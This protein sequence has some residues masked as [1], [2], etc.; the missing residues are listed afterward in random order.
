MCSWELSWHLTILRQ[1]REV[2]VDLPEYEQ[3]FRAYAKAY[4]RSLGESVDVGA[5]RGFFAEAFISASIGGPLRLERMTRLSRRLLRK[6]WGQITINF[7]D[8]GLLACLQR[9]RPPVCYTCS[10]RRK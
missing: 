5:I 3:F 10:Q 7:Q 6:N 9:S 2:M 1:K 8:L 4:E